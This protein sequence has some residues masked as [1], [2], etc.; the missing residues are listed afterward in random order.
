MLDKLNEAFIGGYANAL[1][2]NCRSSRING[3]GY[4]LFKTLA[5]LEVS[6]AN[7]EMV[8]NTLSTSPFAIHSD[9]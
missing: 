1:V 2:V 3:R 8:E 7:T 9:D 4:I 6:L 5:K